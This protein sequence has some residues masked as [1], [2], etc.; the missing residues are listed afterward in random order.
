MTVSLTA[1]FLSQNFHHL[2]SRKGERIGRVIL[3]D[4][5]HSVTMESIQ[6]APN[7]IGGIFDNLTGQQ[8]EDV[9]NSFAMAELETDKKLGPME[10][11]YTATRYQFLLQAMKKPRMGFATPS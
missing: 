1:D 5:E 4:L 11:E 6:G 7:L 9:A 10:T 3:V 2:V 8:R